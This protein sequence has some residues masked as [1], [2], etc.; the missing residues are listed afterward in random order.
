MG[1]AIGSLVSYN[2]QKSTNDSLLTDFIDVAGRPHDTLKGGRVGG[3]AQA[4]LLWAVQPCRL[5]QYLDLQDGQGLI[6]RLDFV[7]MDRNIRIGTRKGGGFKEIDR[8]CQDYL[9][10][11]Y[12][13]MISLQGANFGNRFEA[14]ISASHLWSDFAQ[15]MH[16]LGRD[17]TT[18]G[19]IPYANWIHKL[20]Q[21]VSR[22][23]GII[24][25]LRWATAELNSAEF[26]PSHIDYQ[27]MEAAIA[28]ARISLREH[29]IIFGL[30][31]EESNHG[32]EMQIVNYL[33]KRGGK[34]PREIARGIRFLKDAKTPTSEVRDTLNGLAR[35][36]YVISDGNDTWMAIES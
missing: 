14:E 22:V 17:L 33:L 28:W 6:S 21:K 1:E 26:N 11:L 30:V 20:A 12:L 13:K 34:N 31:D 32:K 24:H 27:T 3:E 29:Q 10:E 15:E 35:R 16:V 7:R 18:Q 2:G 36:G 4:S 19:K 9:K 23:S 5:D 8:A 25:W